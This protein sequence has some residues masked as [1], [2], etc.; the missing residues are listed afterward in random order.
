MT[1]DETQA[2]LAR[3]QAQ[4]EKLLVQQDARQSTDPTELPVY[5]PW[6]KHNPKDDSDSDASTDESGESSDDD[7][8]DSVRNDFERGKWEIHGNLSAILNKEDDTKHERKY[9][10]IK[11]VNRKYKEPIGGWAKSARADPTF[12]KYNNYSVSTTIAKCDKRDAIKERVHG[13][14]FKFLAALD[15]RLERLADRLFNEKPCAI[16]PE[17]TAESIQSIQDDVKEFAKYSLSQKQHTRLERRNKISERIRAPNE[18]RAT[19]K[20]AGSD[21]RE[22]LFGPALTDSF[23]AAWK[24]KHDDDQGKNLSELAKGIQ[25]LSGRNKDKDTRN[26]GNRDYNPRGRGGYRG[27]RGRGNNTYRAQQNNN[28]TT[29][30]TNHPPDAP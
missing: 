27:A 23:I 20:T 11:R 13:V 18:F 8:E 6:G 14:T 2:T 1:D 3:L 24:S 19:L 30:N 15:W 29:R 5:Y 12:H 26:N 25:I 7:W 4:I 10:F 16:T 21:S 28:N 22:Y 9:K 17:A